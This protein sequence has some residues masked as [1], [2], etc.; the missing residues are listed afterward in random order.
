MTTNQSRRRSRFVNV[1]VNG[2]SVAS[3]SSLSSFPG[4][5]N[6]ATDGTREKQIP[7]LRQRTKT[8]SGDRWIKVVPVL[9]MMCAIINVTMF[10]RRTD[11][12]VRFA[13]TRML[14]FAAPSL[15]STPREK[16]TF[17]QS[18]WKRRRR[19]TPW[20]QREDGVSR[21]SFLSMN[22]GVG[23]DK[24]HTVADVRESI[25]PM[26]FTYPSFPV[27]KHAVGIDICGKKVGNKKR[28]DSKDHIII[29]GIFSHPVATELAL[30]LA[31]RCGVRHLVGLSDHLLNAEES[32]RLEFLMRRIPSLQLKVGTGPLG[33][34]ATEELFE[35]HSP[36]HVFYFSSES[37]KIP[38]KD[39]GNEPKSF[40]THSGTD[41]LEQICNTMVKLQPSQSEKAR[42]PKTRLLYITSSLPETDTSDVASMTTLFKFN[43]IMLGAYRLQYQI[44]VRELD[45]PYIF[46]PFQEGAGWL[47]SEDFIRRAHDFGYNDN[48]RPREPLKTVS[49]SDSDPDPDPDPDGAEVITSYNM[50]QPIIS[51]TDAV[52]SILVSGLVAHV[53][54]NT[55]DSILTAAK[56]QTT[57]LLEL[58]KT[59]ASLLLIKSGHKDEKKT[60]DRTLL[61]ILAWN[62][63]QHNPYHDPTDFDISPI[64][65]SA[66][67]TLGLNNTQKY[68]QEGGEIEPAAISIL[69]R[70]QHDI[71][72]CITTCASYVKCTSS[73]WDTT[74]A[75]ARRVSKD[76][77]FVLYTANFSATLDSLPA[78]RESINDVPWPTESFCQIAFVSSKSKVVKNAI[79]ERA[80]GA[81]E[82]RKRINE[83]NGKVSNNGW[84]LV[85][86]DIDDDSISQMDSMIP[87]ILPETLLHPNVQFVFYLEPNR[88]E[89]LPAL[90]LMWFLM[91]QQLSAAA[92]TRHSKGDPDKVWSYPEQH[93]ALFTHTYRDTDV[94]HLDQRKPDFMA[95]AAKFIFEQNGE[96]GALKDE[97]QMQLSNFQQLQSYQNSFQW[98]KDEELKFQLV[99][100]PLMIYPINNRLGQRLRCEW[101]EEHVFWSYEEN[102]NLESLS[103]SYILHRWRRQERFFLNSADEKWGE[104]IMV[105]D[106][107]KALSPSDIVFR[108]LVDKVE[109]GEGI[110][111][112]SAPQHFVKLHSPLNARKFYE[113]Q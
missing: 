76:C 65:N 12:L 54:D 2:R 29:A 34:K 73:I 86:I 7:E 109:A 80:K 42:G 72:P 15:R 48:P 4:N 97:V 37:F 32:F 66:V 69:E 96:I 67:V 91:D 107:G 20:S 101:Y 71:F 68:L 57:T 88:F 58:S 81:G 43:Q 25:M 13:D 14:N 21:L 31:E 89:A 99:D 55:S 41:Q 22:P 74:V 26:K 52:R 77:D 110:D 61:P 90:Q 60:V 46:G 85:W 98:R 100:T 82:E 95:R 40:K 18:K 64:E 51:I 105:G 19:T 94:A 17:E 84:K 106:D 93:V 59:M 49:G 1:N 35:I 62:Y 44:N 10:H 111:P 108:S 102:R 33:D 79:Q 83:L 92:R 8:D 24:N 27:T 11:E 50:T 9:C 16:H 3:S 5:K 38:N 104:M 56:S 30:T 45:L 112:P 39:D 47:F 36:S 75:T 63:K 103:L 87:K 28:Y 6:G 23:H 70:R 113:S 78:M 53:T